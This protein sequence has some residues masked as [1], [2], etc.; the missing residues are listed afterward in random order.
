MAKSVKP[1]MR[2]L[3]PYTIAKYCSDLA[4]VSDGIREIHSF[5][6][7]CEKAKCKAPPSTYIRLWKL[8]QKLL[9]LKK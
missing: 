3:S 7:K 8:S 1:S 9:Q 4:D 2:K 5:I 6:T